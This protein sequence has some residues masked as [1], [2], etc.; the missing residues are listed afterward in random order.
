MSKYVPGKKDSIFI[1]QMVLGKL[2]AH[3]QKN[4]VKPISVTYIKINSKFIKDLNV[5]A[6][7]LKLLEGKGVSYKM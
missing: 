4:E 3:M 2:A 1:Q 6:E 5:K 7:V